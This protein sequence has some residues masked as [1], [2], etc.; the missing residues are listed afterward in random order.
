MSGEGL[1][2]IVWILLVLESPTTI[3]AKKII[4]KSGGSVMYNRLVEKSFLIANEI[5]KFESRKK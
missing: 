5:D 1:A 3:S 4:S 2:N